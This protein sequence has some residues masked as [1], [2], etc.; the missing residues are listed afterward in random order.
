MRHPDAR[1][2][3]PGT[4]YF[5]L[6]NQDITAAVQWHRHNSMSPFGL[7]LMKPGLFCRKESTLLF[8]P[9]SGLSRTGLQVLVNGKSFSPDS[10]TLRISW[11][12]TSPADP[13]V[14]V[15]WQAGP[16]LI[17]ERLSTGND[18]GQE[19]QLIRSVQASYKGEAPS[20][21]DTIQ[22]RLTLA[23]TPY[24]FDG[25]PETS[26]H[27]RGLRASSSSTT[28]SVLLS[29]DANAEVFER[30]ITV[31]GHADEK[32]AAPVIF[33]YSLPD[34]KADRTE[35]GIPHRPGKFS[36]LSESGTFGSAL[37][38]QMNIG[39]IGL[40]SV[41]S[42]DGGF[43]ACIW[44][45]GY[46][47]GQDAAMVASA[48]TYSGMPDLARHVLKNILQNLVN[49]EGR[50]AES[51]R[52]RDGEL[53]EL[54]ANG[55]VLL[56]LRDFVVI[57]GDRTL[58]QEYKEQIEALAELMLDPEYL[59]PSG[60]LCGR[61]DLW[62]RLPWMGLLEGFDTATTTFCAEGLLAAADLADLVSES[63]KAQRWRDAGRRMHDAMLSDERFSCIE[64]G[65]I[66]H[67]RLPDG[68]V[69]DVMKSEST[70]HDSRYAPYV[71]DAVPD[72]TPRPCTP[73]S[74]VAL[75]ILY[76]IVDSDSS[77]A[78]ATLNHLHRHLWDLTGTGG[79]A[80]SPLPS[81]P[82]SPGPWPFVT[83]WMAEAELMAGMKDRAQATTQW[84]LDTA[85]A[86]GSWFEYYGE[87]ESPPY[88]P[89]GIIVWGWAQYI[90]LAVRGWMGIRLS[91]SRLRI[92][93]SITDFE[94]TIP[95]G[96]YGISLNVT[97]LDAI[98]LDGEPAVLHNGGLELRLPLHQNHEISFIRT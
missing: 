3:V 88:P 2:Q 26:V 97:G 78:Q 22:F 59:H 48:A 51:S 86:G 13:A 5:F 47:W 76:G 15:R 39:R 20:V 29:T 85:G 69:Q 12:S 28:F 33:R 81:D 37:I 96:N 38:R 34:T 45:Y 31:S 89:V 68:S 64:D 82:D 17:T 50:V 43:D 91:G 95:V 98:Y 9:E 18:V 1:T 8:H 19:S 40:Q 75:P 58:P 36:S 25:L 54:N 62:E 32:D 56:A 23:P 55:A 60:L 67:R 92:A 46:Q 84:L 52:F 65:L 53:A 6:G 74:T 41:L 21:P 11:D 83:A 44:Q 49:E 30:F 61:R 80:R 93:P 14:L 73:D 72:I 79:Y 66:I 16:L 27:G 87:R 7:L 71:P 4:E 10:S 70:Y 57:T 35:E 77:V 24:L 42:P 94:C 90:L 63:D